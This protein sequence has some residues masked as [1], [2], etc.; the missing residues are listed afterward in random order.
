MHS[1]EKDT[2][3]E[4]G[5]AFIELALDLCIIVALSKKLGDGSLIP[6]GVKVIFLRNSAGI[7]AEIQGVTRLIKQR[8]AE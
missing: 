2:N 1:P 6:A 5:F 3:L 4:S 8:I 7:L